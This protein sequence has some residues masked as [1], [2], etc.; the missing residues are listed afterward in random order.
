MESVAG[1]L[2]AGVAAWADASLAEAVVR[3]AQ[4]VQEQASR[5]WPWI[6]L[7][8]FAFVNLLVVVGRVVAGSFRIKNVLLVAIWPV[9]IPYIR[10]VRRRST[11]RASRAEAA[12]V[13]LMK[14]GGV[15]WSVSRLLPVS[16]GP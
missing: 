1:L 6:V 13:R 16:C 9:F 2:A 8:S 15:T 5:R 11:E 14:P 4:K 10:W 3:R 12:A 7:G